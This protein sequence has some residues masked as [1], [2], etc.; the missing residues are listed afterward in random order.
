LRLIVF[1]VL[2]AVTALALAIGGDAWGW[3]TLAIFAVTLVASLAI[4]FGAHSRR[5]RAP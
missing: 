4:V 5:G 3:L 2:G 1:G